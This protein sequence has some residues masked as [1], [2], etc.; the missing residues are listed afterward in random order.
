MGGAEP[1]ARVIAGILVWEDWKGGFSRGNRHRRRGR[2]TSPAQFGGQLRSLPLA[3]RRGTERLDP[4]FILAPPPNVSRIQ[5]TLSTSISQPPTSLELGLWPLELPQTVP[6]A[7]QRLTFSDVNRLLVISLAGIGDT[8][9]ATPFVHELRLAFPEAAIEALV[10]WPGARSLLEDSPHLSAIHQ[11][12]F[13]KASKFASLRCLWRLRRRRFDV[14]FNV[15]PQ[16]RRDYRWVAWAIGAPRRFSH[17]YENHRP[18]DDRLV[19]DTLPQDY[20]VHASE[21]NRRFLDL[22]GMPSHLPRPAYELYLAAAEATWA[23]AWLTRNQ[24]HGERWLGV[25]VGSGGT[26]NLA[27]RRWPLERYLELFREL[28]EVHPELAVVFFGGPDEAEAHGRLFQELRGGRVYFAEAPSLRHAAALLGRA[29]AFLSVDTLF[30][31]LAA[32]LAVRH[33]FVIE[34][35]TLNPCI[36]PLRPDWTLIPNPAVAGRHLEFYRYDGRP[37]AG[38]R[39]EI[40][41]LMEGV[42][43]ASVLEAVRTAFE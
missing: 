25:H 15:H 35:P 9:M 40:R 36:L 31:H 38:S 27:L 30:M 41:A 12:S 21:N 3:Q 28:E 22:L 5:L 43:V 17:R 24:L 18:F 23:E 7:G 2:R 20:T 1:T 6:L 14:S 13:I 34:T 39:S 33:Q 8:L 26:K 16:G 32:A 42:S 37:I 29:H 19:T 4:Q 10:M 11:H